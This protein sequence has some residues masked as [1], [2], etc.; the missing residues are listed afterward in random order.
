MG[1]RVP[2]DQSFIPRE[3]C[4]RSKGL[5]R[6]RECD[7]KGMIGCLIF[8]VLFSAAIYLSIT[9]GPIYYSNYNFEAEVKQEVSRAGAR[10]L[11]PDTIANDLIRLAKAN[12]IELAQENIKVDRFAGQ[13]HIRVHYTVPVDFIV[14]TKDLNFEIN[15]S[16][17]TGTL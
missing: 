2:A 15:V 11:S 1:V 13:I 16:S 10:F 9:L 8:I 14:M 6:L 3:K 12:D 7:G 5:G 4:M 17:F